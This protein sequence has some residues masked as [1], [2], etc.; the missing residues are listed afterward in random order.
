MANLKDIATTLALM[1]TGALVLTGC[2]S[3]MR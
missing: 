1:G 3:R 2:R